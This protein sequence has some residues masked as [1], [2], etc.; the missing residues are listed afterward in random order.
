MEMFFG[1][2]EEHIQLCNIFSRPFIS[3][4]GYV[5]VCTYVFMY[6]CNKF[7]IAHSCCSYVGMIGYGK[8][9]LSLK[10]SDCMYFPVIVHE[11]GHAIGFYHEQNRPDRDDY[12][13]I[14]EEDISPGI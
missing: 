5:F 7:F 3:I 4:S 13:D 10:P 9:P 6:L 14:I 11:I 2:T 8:Q 12:V 1:L